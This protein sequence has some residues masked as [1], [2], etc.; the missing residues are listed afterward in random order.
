MLDK[1]IYMINIK[2]ELPCLIN[3]SQ[4]ENNECILFN[5]MFNMLS[6]RGMYFNKTKTI[7][8]AIQGYNVAWQTNIFNETISSWIPTE[9]YN[10][11]K[12]ALQ[13]NGVY[14]NNDFFNKL[15][16]EFKSFCLRTNVVS[17]TEDEIKDLLKDCKTNDK[18][19][20]NDGSKP[21]FKNWKRVKPS[22]ESL[23]KIQHYFGQNIRES[24][25]KHKVTAVWSANIQQ[26]SLQFL[27]PNDAIV[28][29]ENN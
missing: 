6:I 12:N 19:Y 4:N 13:Q 5:F 7:T 3:K 23:Y 2:N 10:V 27:N 17:P 11:I 26:K 24:C 9:A 20:G 29:I 8:I 15:Q 1:G 16:D 18:A 14:S 28:E 21:F 25:Y 22:K